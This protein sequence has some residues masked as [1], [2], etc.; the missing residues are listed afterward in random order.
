MD[1]QWIAFFGIEHN[2]VDG[3]KA[4]SV[5]LVF[6]EVALSLLVAELQS[7]GSMFER[8]PFRQGEFCSY[9]VENGCR[10]GDLLRLRIL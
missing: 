9:L 4:R 5:A 6:A 10:W 8:T 2:C 7:L 1:R 3:L